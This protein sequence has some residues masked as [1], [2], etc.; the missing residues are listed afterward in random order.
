M[1]N[2]FKVNNEDVVIVIFERISH[3]V[4]MFL[5]LSL[6]KQKLVGKIRWVVPLEYQGVQLVI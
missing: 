2:L 4:L 5:L 1:W 6:N 3:I